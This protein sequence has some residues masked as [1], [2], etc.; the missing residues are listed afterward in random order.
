MAIEPWVWVVGGLLLIVLELVIPSFFVL[1][2]GLSALLV[3]LW[4]WLFP[5]TS[6]VVQLGVWIVLSIVLIVVWFKVFRTSLHRTRVGLS[7][8]EVLGEI[9][10]LVGPIA[11]FERGRVR[12][13]QPVL[14]SDEWA[15]TADEAL[16]AGTRVKVVRIE[17]QFLKVEAT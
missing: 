1:W 11:P 16:L 10:L 8:G 9:G 7:E 6:L 3:G 14:G 2:F 4:A 12:F 17:G 5:S 13:Q 15:C